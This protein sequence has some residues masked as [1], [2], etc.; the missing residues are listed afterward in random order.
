VLGRA[1]SSDLPVLDPTVSRRHAE[2]TVQQHAVTIRDLGSSN[3]TF[4]NG[5]RITTASLNAG[6]RI[7]FGKMLFELRELSPVLVDDGTAETLRRAARAGTTIIRQI[8][9]PDAGQTLERALRAS[10]VQKAVDETAVVL[11][12]HERD[13]LKLTLLL[14]VS[15]ALT[16]LADVD[17]L[18]EKIVDF[19]FRTI[20]ADQVSVLLRDEAGMLALHSSRTSS[21]TNPHEVPLSVARTAVDEKVALLSDTDG[22]GG[23]GAGAVGGGARS[24]APHNGADQTKR[25]SVCAPLVASEGRVLGVLY[26]AS[27]ATSR[28]VN[29]EDLDFLVSFAGIGA[30]AID[31]IRFAERIRREALVRGN[32]ERFFTP[33]LAARIAAAPDQLRLGGERRRVA[34]LF[35]DIRGFTPLASRL[36]PDETASLLNE[37]FSEMAECVFRHGGTLDKFIGDSVMAQWGAP[38]S[39]SD[40]ADRAV[41]AALDMMAALRRLNA[42]WERQGRP[43]LEMGIGINF[44]EAFAGFVGSERRL[45]YTIIGDTVNTANRLCAAAQAGEILASGSLRDALTRQHS[46]VEHPALD[47][48]GRAAPLVVLRVTT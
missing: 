12:Q 21:G 22:S 41:E 42:G 6:D 18:I 27:L 11:P 37:Y 36:T 5:D 34:V 9:V 2:L 26:V 44:G 15:K 48:P 47:F 30:V 13:R 43:K 39:E 31:N 8:P 3:G 38:L 17:D 29:D 32:F 1:L 24:G 46:L 28:R 16:R 23:G 45:E 19:T 25:T 20:D 4:V 40:D 35:S 10:G 33:H 7:I 14:E